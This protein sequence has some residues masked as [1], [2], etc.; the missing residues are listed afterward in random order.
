MARS[1]GSSLRGRESL[2]DDDGPAWLVFFGQRLPTPS[3]TA[4]QPQQLIPALEHLP[5][6]AAVERT[7]F[8]L[9]LSI[10]IERLQ[11]VNPIEHV[12]AAANGRLPGIV[13]PLVVL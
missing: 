4:N 11:G 1:S 8:A 9:E 13:G 2:A 3:P 6:A 10:A 5:G 12:A 7:N